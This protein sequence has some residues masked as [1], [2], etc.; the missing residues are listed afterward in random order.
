MMFYKSTK[1]TSLLYS[2]KCADVY[3]YP[4]FGIVNNHLGRFTVKSGFSMMSGNRLHSNI[5][6]ENYKSSGL[7]LLMLF[8]KTETIQH[9]LKGFLQRPSKATKNCYMIVDFFRIGW[10]ICLLIAGAVF[11]HFITIVSQTYT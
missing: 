10:K 4:S 9:C 7:L 2:E 3:L 8:V 6:R 11:Y 5:R 1:K